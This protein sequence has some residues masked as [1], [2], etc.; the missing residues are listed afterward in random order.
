MTDTERRLLELRQRLLDYL[1]RHPYEQWTDDDTDYQLAAAC[2]LANVTDELCSLAIGDPMPSPTMLE[3]LDHMKADF[4]YHSED[5]KFI[6]LETIW[7]DL[8]MEDI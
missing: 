3:L 4:E 6:D 2:T 5:P 1:T 7:C 8:T